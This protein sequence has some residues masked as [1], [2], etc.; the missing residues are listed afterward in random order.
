MKR[1]ILVSFLLLYLVYGFAQKTGDK[2]FDKLIHKWTFLQFERVEK[3][4]LSVTVNKTKY[5]DSIT[6]EFKPDQTLT[7]VYPASKTENYNWRFKRK[8]IVITST[9]INNPAIPGIYEIH[10]LDKISQLFLQRR[11]QPHNGI[12]LR[13]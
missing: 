11:R 7:V 5:A 2:K 13:Y 8:F 10:F 3:N 4:G 9:G 12:M 1:A 6:F